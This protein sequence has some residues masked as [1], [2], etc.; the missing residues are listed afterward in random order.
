[1]LICWSM[2]FTITIINFLKYV[3]AVREEDGQDQ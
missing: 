3:D 2:C 1:M